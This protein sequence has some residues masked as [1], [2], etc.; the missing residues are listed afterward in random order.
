MQVADLTVELVKATNDFLGAGLPG[1]QLLFDAQ[2]AHLGRTRTEAIVDRGEEPENE[3]EGHAEKGALGR[4]AAKIAHMK[5]RGVGDHLVGDLARWRH[6][7]TAARGLGLVV[8]QAVLNTP[9][10]IEVLRIIVHGNAGGSRHAYLAKRSRRDGRPASR[11]GHI[12]L[13]SATIT[14]AA[15]E[16]KPGSRRG[17]ERQPG[18][19]G[20]PLA[21]HRGR[22]D[23]ALAG[24]GAESRRERA[25]RLKEIGRPRLRRCAL[26]GRGHRGER[27]GRGHA[28]AAASHRG[29]R[30]RCAQRLRPARPTAAR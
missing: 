27:I 2:L 25:I 26:R 12:L 28:W 13:G 17:I 22:H 15:R 21:G 4:P 29:L 16:F 24:R 10:E 19:G 7:L 23:L 8:V 1:E 14:P 11:G 18:A 30:M 5:D 20:P 6:A 3:G 9:D